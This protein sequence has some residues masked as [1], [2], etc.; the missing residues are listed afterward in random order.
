MPTRKPSADALRSH[1]LLSRQSSR[2]LVV[3]VQDKL[4]PLIPVA[5]QLIRN[6]RRL[7]QAARLIDVPV[8]ATEQYPQGLGRTVSELA[9]LLGDALTKQRFSGSEALDWGSAAALD[10]DR[11]QVVVAGMEAH[12]CVLQTALDLISQGFR[13]YIPA[14]SVAS[15]NKLD[16]KLALDRLAA[17]GATV[18]TTESVLFEWCETSA[19]AQFKQI[20]QLIKDG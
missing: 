5:E 15:R 19:A 8:Y 6:C 1:E 18:T 13:V 12:V 14:D 7:I 10:D 11:D 16:W 20:S 3:D 9:E 2:L 17:S 4:V